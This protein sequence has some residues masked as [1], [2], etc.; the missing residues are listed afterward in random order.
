MELLISFLT[1]AAA[2]YLAFIAISMLLVVIIYKDRLNSVEVNH[3][4]FALLS[5]IFLLWRAFG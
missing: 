2:G 1:W 4:L 5:I 3:P